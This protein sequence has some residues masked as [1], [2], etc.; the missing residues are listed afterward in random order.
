LPDFV[1]AAVRAPRGQAVVA[2]AARTPHGR[3][4]IVG[5]LSGAW[6]IAASDADSVATEHG[7]A[8]LRDASLDERVRRMLAIAHPQDRE[9]LAAQARGLGLL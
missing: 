5:R 7:V 1:R 6:T 8:H 2:L 3:P 4:R 9:P